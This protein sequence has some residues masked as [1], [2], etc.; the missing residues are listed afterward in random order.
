MKLDDIG[1]TKLGKKFRECTLCSRQY[2]ISTSISVLYTHVFQHKELHE[3]L[4]K[5]LGE[6]K[7]Q[8]R[9]SHLPKSF[10]LKNN[11]GIEISQDAL[12]ISKNS[13]NSSDSFPRK[14]KYGDHSTYRTSKD[15]DFKS[16]PK[17][18]MRKSTENLALQDSSNKYLQETYFSLSSNRGRKSSLNVDINYVGKGDPNTPITSKKGYGSF[19]KTDVLGLTKMVSSSHRLCLGC[20]KKFKTTCS[21]TTLYKHCIRHPQQRAILKKNLAESVFNN[22]LKNANISD[23]NVESDGVDSENSSDVKDNSS[24]LGEKSLSELL[25]KAKHFDCLNRSSSSSVSDERRLDKGLESDA[26]TLDSSNEKSLNESML[27][28]VKRETVNYGKE[29][30]KELLHKFVQICG[31]PEKLISACGIENLSNFFRTMVFQNIVKEFLDNNVLRKYVDSDNFK[32]IEINGLSLEEY[33]RNKTTF[34][35]IKAFI[36]DSNLSIHSQNLGIISFNSDINV[37]DLEKI[38]IQIRNILSNYN[39]ILNKKPILITNGG[40]LS[41]FLSVRKNF[42]EIPC[43]LTEIIRSI[44]FVQ[45]KSGKI[46]DCLKKAA[47]KFSLYKFVVDNDIE[48]SS[49]LKDISGIEAP[50]HWINIYNILAFGAF[51]IIEA[52]FFCQE[53]WPSLVLS[54]EELQIVYKFLMVNQPIVKILN[55]LTSNLLNMT[56]YLEVVYDIYELYENY[57]FKIPGNDITELLRS[58]NAIQIENIERYSDFIYSE[59]FYLPKKNINT[60]DSNDS[61]NKQ[62][63]QMLASLRDCFLELKNK[64][65][66]NHYI[67]R[68]LLLN[69][70]EA[71]NL[72]YGDT[73]FWSFIESLFDSQ[74]EISNYPILQKKVFFNVEAVNDVQLY[75]NILYRYEINSLDDFWLS[76]KHVLPTMYKEYIDAL[77][78][79]VIQNRPDNKENLF[80]WAKYSSNL[81]NICRNSI[82]NTNK[83]ELSYEILGVD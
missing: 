15:F 43:L 23:N 78:I 3:L 61:T 22:A 17:K 30:F 56:N 82:N 32:I 11:V 54:G 66:E 39:Q 49:K 64:S 9:L 42:I 14:R 63:N 8:E 29:N 28:S 48:V 36:L 52:S 60:S 18:S 46:F 83:E 47:K 24:F 5:K 41:K 4:R 76:Q 73:T 53:F 26:R 65:K 57:E 19:F 50:M 33:S 59:I 34:A 2:S 77:S 67:C 12:N 71:Y 75:R 35:V 62:F 21:V 51:N 10:R 45:S 25:E 27:S 37:N 58:S 68:A 81:E 80:D 31:L 79:P 44:T 20:N 72:R 70:K 7:F 16:E 1:V 38:S 40:L 6:K 55:S 74:F 69:T 13:L